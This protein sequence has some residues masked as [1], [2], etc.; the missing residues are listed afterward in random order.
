[1]NPCSSLWK[2]TI[3]LSDSKDM[4]KKKNKLCYIYIYKTYETT[5]VNW[6]IYIYKVVCRPVTTW[7]VYTRIYIYIHLLT[8]RKMRQQEGGHLRWQSEVFSQSMCSRLLIASAMYSFFY[9][10]ALFWSISNNQDLIKMLF[11]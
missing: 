6:N 1:M 5:E 2:K 8:T 11:I 4:N 3:V 9:I 10:R 7:N